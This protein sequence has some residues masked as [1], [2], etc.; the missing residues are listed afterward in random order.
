MPGG[1][2]GLCRRFWRIV[3]RFLMMIEGPAPKLAALLIWW[4]REVGR[5]GE[6][7]GGEWKKV[8]GE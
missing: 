1:R 7:G 6:L 5:W 8:E 4:G 2:L 3:I